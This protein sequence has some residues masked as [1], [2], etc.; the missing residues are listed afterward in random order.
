MTVVGLSAVNGGVSWQYSLL[1]NVVFVKGLKLVYVLF[2]FVIVTH[3]ICSHSIVGPFFHFAFG[4]TLLL[5]S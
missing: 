3:N 5:V 4:K 2:Y 1:V